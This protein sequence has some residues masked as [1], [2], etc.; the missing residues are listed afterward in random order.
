MTDV[1][2]LAARLYE[3]I[4]WQNVPHDIGREDMT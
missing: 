1:I 2:A 3:R 4:E